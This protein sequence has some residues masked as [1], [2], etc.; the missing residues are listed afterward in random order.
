MNAFLA[1]ICTFLIV[2]IFH[3]A[4]EL[5]VMR[6]TKARYLLRKKTYRAMRTNWA[7]KRGVA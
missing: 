2:T 7:A 3:F 4:V 5:E 6:E 1:V